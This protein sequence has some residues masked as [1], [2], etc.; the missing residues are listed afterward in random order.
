MIGWPAFVTLTVALAGQTAPAPVREPIDD[1]RVQRSIE[2]ARQFLWSIW[3]E[4]DGHWPERGQRGLRKGTGI[5]INYGGTTALCAYAMLAAGERHQS[6]RMRRTLEWLRDCPMH[7][8]YAV[9]LRANVWSL[10]PRN[11]AYRPA[12]RRDLEWLT[13]SA[14][15]ENGAYGYSAEPRRSRRMG[16]PRYDNSNSQLAVLGVWSAAM[17]GEHVPRQYWEKV[18]AH[19]RREQCRDGGWN[20]GAT[21]QGSSGSYGSMTA[22]GLATMFICFDA[23]HYEEFADATVEQEY[24]PLTRGLAWMSKYFTAMGNPRFERWFY[25]YLYGVERVGLASGF[26]YFGERD[27]YKEGV[28]RLLK[29]QRPEGFWMGYPVLRDGEASR[30]AY[31]PGKPSAGNND[32]STSFALLFLARGQHPILFNK[33]RYNGSWNTR[34]R[35]CA[36]LARWITATFENQVQWQIIETAAPVEDWHDAPVLYISGKRPPTFSE[37]ELGKLRTFVYQGGVILSEAVLDSESFTA[38][39][40]GLYE[41]MFPDCKPQPLPEE[42][43][44]Y[45]LHFKLKKHPKLTAVSNGVRL[46]AIHSPKDLS[47]AFQLRAYASQPELFQLV[48]NIYFYVTDKE[49]L[50]HRGVS[51]W[52]YAKKPTSQ[53][54]I[55]IAPLKHSGAWNPEPLAWKRFAIL[56]GNRHGIRIEVAEPADIGKLRYPEAQIAVMTGTSGFKLS[57][58]EKFFLRKFCL[59]NTDYRNHGEQEA[60]IERYLAWR[61][62]RR[63]ISLKDWRRYRRAA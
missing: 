27:W 19:W 15:L 49:P 10:L 16:N 18:D 56:M 20:Y 1:A 34:P 3:D 13:K 25:Y 35:D 6:P 30:P 5:A 51:I 57:N 11:S 12:L 7:G 33:L 46:L 2:K 17:A 23:I 60:T 48:A 45:S 55:R 14:L 24:P 53:Q 26:K 62:R 40:I 59:D 39:M 8:T 9:A 4:Q 43:P 44:I 32:I 38:A 63:S 42:H 58:T 29:S 47:R 22:A 50:R 36:N 54:T 61:N 31:R 37:E 41:K 21:F 52:P 28:S